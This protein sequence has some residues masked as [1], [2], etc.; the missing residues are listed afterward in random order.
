MAGD[1]EGFEVAVADLLA[2]GVVAL[3]EGGFDLESG[4]C[5]GGVELTRFAGQGW[6]VDYAAVAAVSWRMVAS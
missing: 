2:E 5:G 6:C 3:V 1:G 4:G